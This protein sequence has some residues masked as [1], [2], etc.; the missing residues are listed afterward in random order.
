MTTP[1]FREPRTAAG[2][3]PTSGNLVPTAHA[4]SGVALGLGAVRL[5]HQALAARRLDFECPEVST[6]Q[7]RPDALDFA[8][9][10]ALECDDAAGLGPVAAPFAQ[11]FHQ[12][13]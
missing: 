11:L 7:D 9:R 12:S 2:S 6:P 5:G 4:S 3:P 13:A 10:R 8:R 1:T